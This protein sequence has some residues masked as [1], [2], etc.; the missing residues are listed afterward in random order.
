MT[1]KEERLIPISELQEMLGLRSRSQF[2][3]WERTMERFPPRITISRTSV[4]YR[5]S[6]VRSFLDGLTAT[7]GTG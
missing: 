1:T 2:L 7:G 3:V 6:D 4:R 5:A